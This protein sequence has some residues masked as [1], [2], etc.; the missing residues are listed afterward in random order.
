MED[1]DNSVPDELELKSKQIVK[2]L[3]SSGNSKSDIKLKA[4]A[5]LR[6]MLRAKLDE[7]IKGTITP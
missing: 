2:M 7:L 4:M 3:F 5:D 6:K 1:W